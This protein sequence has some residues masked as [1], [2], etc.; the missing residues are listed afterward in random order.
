MLL[1]AQVELSK[2][3]AKEDMAGR[4]GTD[5]SGFRKKKGVEILFEMVIEMVIG[6][7]RAR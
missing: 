2:A 5:I 4:E 7:Q 1:T 3:V 6:R